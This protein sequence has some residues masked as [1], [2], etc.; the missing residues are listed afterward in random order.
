MPNINES[1]SATL[2]L[3]MFIWLV[4]TYPLS[5]RIRLPQGIEPTQRKLVAHLGI[6]VKSRA[7]KDLETVGG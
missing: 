1:S 7:F 4:M 2:L 3:L 5:R 6:R